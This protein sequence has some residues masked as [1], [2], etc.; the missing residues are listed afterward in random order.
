MNY[1]NILV[2]QEKSILW[3]KLNRPNAMN[4]LNQE[5]I[6]ELIEALQKA[7]QDETVDVIILKGEGRGFCAG[8]DLKTF[9]IGG[10]VLD[11][12]IANY[13]PWQ[14]IEEMSKPTIAAVHG[15]VITGGYVVAIACDIIIAAE[16]ATFADTH[17]RWGLIPYGG[18]TV[19][20]SVIG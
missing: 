7:D 1:S 13:G 2:D 4:A 16:N 19:W 14:A 11:D 5:L 6:T 10:G 15:A 12:V 8:M 20:F 9:P 18:E 3:I 17:A